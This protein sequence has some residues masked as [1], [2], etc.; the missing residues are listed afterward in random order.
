M[1]TFSVGSQLLS[2]YA[3]ERYARLDILKQ[4]LEATFAIKF[5]L[6]MNALKFKTLGELKC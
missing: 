5:C 4:V 2:V 3:L 6:K 1:E